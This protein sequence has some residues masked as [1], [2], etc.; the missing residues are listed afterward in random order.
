MESVSGILAGEDMNVEIFVIQD[1]PHNMIEL[2]GIRGLIGSAFGTAVLSGGVENASFDIF[3]SQCH[4]FSVVGS[5][6]EL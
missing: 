1:I 3:G 5:F 2:G 4:V 6:F